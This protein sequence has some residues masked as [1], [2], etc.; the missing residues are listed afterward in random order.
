MTAETISPEELRAKLNEFTL[1]DVRESDEEGCIG[2]AKRIPLG[3][4]IRDL[5][6]LSL[7]EKEIVV[8]CKG[9]V[10]G[11]I[12]ADFLQSKGYKVRNLAGGFKAY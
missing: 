9:G 12:A 2:N 11:Q 1:I 4:F 3:K 5:G 10:R 6:T 7:G 8:Y